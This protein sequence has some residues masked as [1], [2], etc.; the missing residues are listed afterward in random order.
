M[1]QTERMCNRVAAWAMAAPTP[2]ELRPAHCEIAQ[3]TVS[4]ECLVQL[5]LREQVRLTQMKEDEY[6]ATVER[7]QSG[8]NA[9][10]ERDHAA[11][12]RE[13]KRLLAQDYRHQLDLHRWTDAAQLEAERQGMDDE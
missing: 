13:G 2:G 12:V 9:S 5:R 8:Q 7:D 10:A 1:L 6:W 4:K 3:R 11:H